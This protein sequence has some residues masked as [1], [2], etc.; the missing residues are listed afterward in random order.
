MGVF[1]III[2]IASE[3]PYRRQTDHFG[4]RKLEVMRPEIK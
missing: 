1:G 4:R 2:I 3:L